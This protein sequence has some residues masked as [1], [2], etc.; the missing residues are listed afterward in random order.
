ML[1]VRENVIDAEPFPGV[2]SNRL[3]QLTL[4]MHIL[5]TFEDRRPRNVGN[6]HALRRGEAPDERGYEKASVADILRESSVTKGAMYFHFAS[7]E[8]VGRAV[9]LRQAEM[10]QAIDPAISSCL[11][12]RSNPRGSGSCERPAGCLV[13]LT[14]IAAGALPSPSALLA[15]LEAGLLLVDDV[16]AAAAAHHLGTGSA[17]EVTDR[18]ADLHRA[19]PFM[20][21]GGSGS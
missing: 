19:S 20:K 10:V 5:E 2:L 14:E 11:S 12:G 18:G 7:K 1:E 4:I 21:A 15:T 6:C 16:Q 17:G 13:R 9:L 3:P 8:D